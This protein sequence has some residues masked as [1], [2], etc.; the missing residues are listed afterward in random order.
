MK[1]LLTLDWVSSRENPCRE[2]AGCGGNC[3]P[4][5]IPIL[6]TSESKFVGLKESEGVVCFFECCWNY[7]HHTCPFQWQTWMLK[8]L[9]NSR[10]AEELCLAQTFFGP[11]IGPSSSISAPFIFHLSIQE[12]DLREHMMIEGFRWSIGSSIWNS[13]TTLV[14]QWVNQQKLVG[15]IIGFVTV[16]MIKI[17]GLS[18]VYLQM[19]SEASGWMMMKSKHLPIGHFRW[20]RCASPKFELGIAQLTSAKHFT[21]FHNYDCGLHSGIVWHRHW[22]WFSLIYLIVH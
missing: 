13:T 1:K 16:E 21:I 15:F 3:L 6:W 4:K 12:K 7:S 18:P 9:A 20:F 14:K 10:I 19:G 8:E 22:Y 11:Q 2:V 17:E 5:S